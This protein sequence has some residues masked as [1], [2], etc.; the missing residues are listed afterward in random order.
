MIF[1]KEINRRVIVL[2]SID[3]YHFTPE[4]IKKLYIFM[5]LWY[6]RLICN[7]AVKQG[8]YLK[9]LDKNGEVYYSLNK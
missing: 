9:H 5:P 1:N 7:D 2:S 6:M 8:L 3:P 4:E